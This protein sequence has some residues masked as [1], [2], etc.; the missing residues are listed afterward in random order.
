[1]ALTGK[2]AGADSEMEFKYVIMRFP[3]S[4][5]DNHL[6]WRYRNKSRKNQRGSE[7]A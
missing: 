7:Q 4:H 2:L 6:E 3:E 5:S 1:V